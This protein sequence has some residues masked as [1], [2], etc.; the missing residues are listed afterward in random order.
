MLSWYD[1]ALITCVVVL[2]V[3]T[4]AIAVTGS[5]VSECVTRY[6]GYAVYRDP[7]HRAR[8]R[9]AARR[10]QR[11]LVVLVLLWMALATATTALGV[12]SY[13]EGKAQTVC[14]EE[15]AK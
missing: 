11:R 5:Q 14:A 7:D 13:R 10:Y 15:K 2:F 6:R 9:R 12:V 3:C 1:I 4:F 8:I